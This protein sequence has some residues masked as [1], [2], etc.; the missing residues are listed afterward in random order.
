MFSVS[1]NGGLVGYFK[2]TTGVRQGDLLS[3]YIF[4]IAMDVLSKLLDATVVHGIFYY[5]PKCKRIT[6]THLCFADDLMIFTKGNLHSIV[7]IQNVLKIFYTYSGLQLNAA[8][9]EFFST[10]VSKELLEEIQLITG[11]KRGVLP[12][13]YLGVPLVTRRLTLKDCSP[14]IDKISAR[15]NGWSARL[16]TYAGRL[17]LIQAI[18][19]SIQNF[20]SRHFILP[21]VVLRRISQ[22]CSGFL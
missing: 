12:V 14:L 10:G 4:V 7:G 11:F 5:H 19:Y 22:L 15:I 18:L 9:S 13:R 16:L 1:F 8:K 3:P 20:W 21:K 6:L 2:R 17:Q